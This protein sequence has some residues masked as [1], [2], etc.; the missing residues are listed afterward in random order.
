MNIENA[1]AIPMSEILEKIGCAPVSRKGSE[2][3]YLSPLRLEKTPSFHIH[4]AKNLWYDFGDGVGG[5]PVD[6]ARA[7][8]R[9]QGK[10]ATVSRALQ[11]L[12]SLL[13]GVSFPP[14]Q[15]EKP[16]VQE[17]RKTLVV[18]HVQTLRYPALLQ[19]LRER[20]VPERLAAGYL[21][22]VHV[23]NTITG[24]T[25]L[26]LGMRNENDGYELR[27]KAFKGSITAKGISFFRGAEPLPRRVHVFEGFMD[28]LSALAEEDGTL[29][30]D[31]IVLHSTSLLAQALP[32][33][34]DYTYSDVYT[35]FDNDRAG[36][37]AT[38]TLRLFASREGYLAVH[39]MNA[40]YRGFKDVNAWR[41]RHPKP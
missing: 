1:N 2:V 4:V 3:W 18:S 23:Y 31:L 34:K 41:M 21:K 32:Y 10:S 29:D 17:S 36:L 27:N 20:N 37:Y 9:M 25:F 30:G 35:W 22:E 24:K 8:L 39:P 26:A 33:I 40:A 28:M 7:Y 12:E 5:R 14:P 13:P 6:F 15:R 11:W 16:F 19:Y 38:E